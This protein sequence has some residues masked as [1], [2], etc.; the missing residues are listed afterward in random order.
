MAP[1]TKKEFS[2]GGVVI[3]NGRTLLIR[4]RT[5]AGRLVWTFPK[6]HLEPGETAEA[7]AL[8][9][10]L[11][12]TGCACRITG[13]LMTAHYGFT[14]AGGH[15]DKEVSW[16]LMERSGGDRE[17][18][19]PDEIFGMKWCNGAETA[20]SLTYPSDLELFELIKSRLV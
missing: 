4:M 3:E 8:R 18:S 12:E 19:T 17:P 10:V 9:E 16:Y 15:V 13:A 6:G 5:L 7:A 11:E 1:G 14:R 2:A 20:A